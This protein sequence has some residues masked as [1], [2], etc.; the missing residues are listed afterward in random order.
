MGFRRLPS[1]LALILS[2]LVVGWSAGPT[3]SSSAAITNSPLR[4]AA[5]ANRVVSFGPVT[6]RVPADWPV[7]NLSTHPRACPRLSVHAVYLGTP[8]PDPA[9]PAEELAGKTEAV[10]LMPINPASPDVRAATRQTVISGL[11]AQT[12]TNSSISHTIIDLLPAAGV[13]VSLSYAAD[14]PL[15]RSIQASIRIAASARSGPAMTAV[16]PTAIPAA[17]PQGLYRGPGFDTCSAPA[18]G[19][20]SRWLASPYRAIGI[21]IGGINRACA[22]TSLT[23][24]WIAEIQRQGWHY[25]PFYVGPQAAC[26]DAFGDVPISSSHPA[27]EGTADARDAVQ[28]A[29]DLGIPAGTPL[30]Y[31]MEAYGTGCTAQ[32]LT[33]LSAWDSEVLA[34][35]YEPGVYESFSNIGDL[36]AAR[37]RMTEPTVI[38]YADWDGQA[39]TNSSYMPAT[40]WAD[41]QRLHQYMGGNNQTWAGVTMNI[42]LDQLDVNLGGQSAQPPPPMPFP[43][44]FRLAL[45]MNSNGSAEWFAL[46]SSGTMKHAYQHPIGTSHWAPS[47]NVGN[48]PADLV[49]NPAVTADQNGRLTVFALDKAGRVIHAWQRQGAPN[50]WQWAGAVG[51]GS[52]GKLTGDPA[53]TQAPG[54]AVAVFA[55]D[56][57]GAVMTT[58]QR[59]PDYNTGWTPWTSIGGSCASSPLAY[60]AP[61]GPI[62]V[63]CVTR[64]GR[65]ATREQTAGGWRAWRTVPGLA[66]LAGVPA[67]V[68]AGQGRSEVFASTRS[69]GLEAAWQACPAS[70]WT[71]VPGPPPNRK[72]H[73]SPTATVWPGGA[74]AAFAELAGGE[75]GY[76]V[77][78]PAGSARWTSWRPLASTVVGVPV[79]WRNTFGPPA[80][81]V[82]DGSREVAVSSYAASR[83]SSWLEV[84]GGF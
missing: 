11:P 8:G 59:A 27:A 62:Q 40:M 10:Q 12:N 71:A 34:L 84:G 73:G 43:F 70:G 69:G 82:L 9:C 37:G 42:D 15:M 17:A 55:A 47:R 24:G 48:S 1:V 45:G 4:P 60:T 18:A 52:P 20:M 41:H 68:S 6:L 36:I 25:F 78:R 21:Y 54:G 67:V 26:V 49:S 65:L 50:D 28:Q 77:Q 14:L 22:Q 31:D 7:I 80:A 23:A 76:A 72:V 3:A 16:S 75:L 2:S 46:G 38:H 53:A 83:W 63:F 74:V 29:E 51:T 35:G 33:F 57:S 61:G 58:R 39:T 64:H 79:A 30:I 81:A 5:T 13:E 44:L 32:V 19:T 56:T 66:R